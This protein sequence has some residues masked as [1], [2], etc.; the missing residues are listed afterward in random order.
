[1][2]IIGAAA[3]LPTI[4]DALKPNKI[5]GKILSQYAN[6]VKL[7]NGHDS[8]VILQKLSIYSKTKISI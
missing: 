3:W 7:T 8:A 4:F 1:M 6:I 2:G 5:E